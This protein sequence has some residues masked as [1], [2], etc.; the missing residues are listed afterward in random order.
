MRRTIPSLNSLRYFEAAARHRSFSR[1]G[2]ALAVSHASV[3]RQIQGLETA[4]GVLLFRRAHRKV[5]LT[6]AGEAL[7]DVVK[8]GLDR[9]EATAARLAGTEKPR[10]LILAADSI[11]TQSWLLPRFNAFRAANPS[12]PLTVEARADVTDIPEDADCAICYFNRPQSRHIHVPMYVNRQFVVTSPHYL[13]RHPELRDPRGL[14]GK[15]LVHD[16]TREF[17]RLMAGHLGLDLPWEQGP[18]YEDTNVMVAAVTGGEGVGFGD[19]MTCRPALESGRLVVPFL[20]FLTS[21]FVY[22]FSYRAELAAD[23]GVI[24][25]REWVL[26][27]AQAHR[28]WFDAFWAEQRRTTP[29]WIAGSAMAADESRM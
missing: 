17:W 1:A 12:V 26:D 19:E 18:L 24:A 5:T 7:F 15:N 23:P 25:L 9:I 6:P 14:L 13:E 29:G 2:E 20:S 10:P 3:S 11:L 27:Q 21:R 28:E 22:F 8:S 4:L 16:R